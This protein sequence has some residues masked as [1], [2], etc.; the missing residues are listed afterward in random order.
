M[1]TRIT[2]RNL[3]FDPVRGVNLTIGNFSF[4]FDAEGN[5]IKAFDDPPAGNGQVIDVCALLA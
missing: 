5:L 3:P 1:T 2:G 4:V